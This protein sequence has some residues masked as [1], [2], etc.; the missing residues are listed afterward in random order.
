MDGVETQRNPEQGSQRSKRRR[1][2]RKKI[3]ELWND[4]YQACLRLKA[5]YVSMVDS[6]NAESEQRHCRVY[7]PYGETCGYSGKPLCFENMLFMEVTGDV[8]RRKVLD[9][10]RNKHARIAA[11][12]GVEKK[13]E[14][15]PRSLEDDAIVQLDR[16]VSTT[17]LPYD[18]DEVLIIRSCEDSDEAVESSDEGS[19]CTEVRR[20][21]SCFLILV[22]VVLKSESHLPAGP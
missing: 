4:F 6:L 15:H 3:T 14:G 22:L 17:L 20:H 19:V 21:M 2:A 12:F 13:G 11:R 9:H 10:V 18:R 1:V 8:D 5:P 7:C 16:Q